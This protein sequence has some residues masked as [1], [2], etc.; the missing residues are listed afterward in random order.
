VPAA[1]AL[2]ETV[3]STPARE[4][5][6]GEPTWAGGILYLIH[7]L[8][9]AELLRQFDTGLG[10]WALLE[11]LG[12]CLLDDTPNLA[13]D[14]I[15]AA[16]AHLDSRDPRTPPGLAFKPQHTYAAPLS[17]LANA[18]EQP[19]LVRFRSRGLEIWSA[20]GFLVLDSEDGV[21][22]SGALRPLTSS[23]RRKL[24]RPARVRPIGLSLSPELRRFLHFVLPYARWRLDRALRGARLEEALLRT[25]RLYLTATHVDLVMPMKEISVPVRLAGLDANPGWMRELGRVVTFHFVQ[26]GY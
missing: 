19:R 20:E 4:W 6:G 12:R 18:A 23:R 10:G 24:R 8:R 22:P 25:G 1:D 7:F 11:L 21:P 3:P 16:L 14:A 17:W 26:E 13:D 9:Q 5:E 2:V 15:W